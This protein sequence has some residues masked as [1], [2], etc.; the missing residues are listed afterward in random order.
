MTNYD[1]LM[2]NMTPE[3]MA[4]LNVHLVTVDN[5]KLFYMTSSGQLFN[6]NDYQSAVQ[7]EYNWLM[8]DPEAQRADKNVDA[9]ND[10]VD[11]SSDFEGEPDSA[12]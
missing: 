12:E 4:E 1:S 11:N 10:A 5:R 8:Y 9:S 3:A 2:K 7:F 6:N